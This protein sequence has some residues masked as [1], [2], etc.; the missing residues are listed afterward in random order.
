MVAM[1]ALMMGALYPLFAAQRDAMQA[2]REAAERAAWCARNPGADAEC[3]EKWQPMNPNNYS[4]RED[5]NSVWTCTRT[6]DEE[7]VQ[8]DPKDGSAGVDL[9]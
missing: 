5:F 6:S 8:A 4:C 9:P 7:P 1:V 3:P 2:E